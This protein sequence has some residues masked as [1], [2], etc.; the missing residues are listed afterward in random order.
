MRGEEHPRWRTD[1]AC[2][3]VLWR[4]EG[5]TG[6]QRGQ[7][8]DV[9]RGREGDE[10]GKVCSVADA[11]LEGSGG[12]QCS[13]GTIQEGTPTGRKDVK[14]AEEED[15]LEMVTFEWH[16][17]DAR[18]PWR[19]R[20]QPGQKPR[21]VSKCGLGGFSKN[22]HFVK[23]SFVGVARPLSVSGQSDSLQKGTSETLKPHRRAA[24]LCSPTVPP[25]ID[26]TELG[27]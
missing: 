22:N 12:L 11:G 7:S 4:E 14:E 3:K 8:R 13:A 27:F 18:E 24:S 15:C 6:S 17:R 23:R 26:F 21:G 2:A 10:A 9:R 20:K 16:L 19:Q 5:S 25:I 1:T